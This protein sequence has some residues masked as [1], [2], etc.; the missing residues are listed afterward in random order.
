MS[1]SEKDDGEALMLMGEMATTGNQAI[2][3]LKAS[4]CSTTSMICVELLGNLMAKALA[5]RAVARGYRQG[6]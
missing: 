6:C 5:V 2:A 3:F 4:R 1:N